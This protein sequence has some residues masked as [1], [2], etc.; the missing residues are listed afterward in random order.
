M[1][2]KPLVA[3]HPERRPT[4]LSRVQPMPVVGSAF[5]ASP[6]A[7]STRATLG[8]VPKMAP[9][10]R[11]PI[12]PAVTRTGNRYILVTTDIIAPSGLKQRP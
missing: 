4:V 12:H 9:R 2:S 6:D 1:A 11:S 3:H 8:A 5:E 7:A 10:L